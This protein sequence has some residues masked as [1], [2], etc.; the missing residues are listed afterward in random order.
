MTV[1]GGAAGGPVAGDPDAG[2]V[3]LLETVPAVRDALIREALTPP[4][5]AAGGG[6]PGKWAWADAAAHAA[7]HAMRPRRRGAGAG[8]GAPAR[9]AVSSADVWPDSDDDG[10]L[11]ALGG[12]YSADAFDDAAMGAPKCGKCGAPAEKRCSRC[13]NEWYCSREC[14]VAAWKGHKDVCDVVA[15]GMKAA[16]AAAAGG[17]GGVA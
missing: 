4:A 2:G 5:G 9:R 11:R 13:H 3:L 1:A 6:R 7:R 12:V 10:D 15:A 8:A 16:A 14:Q 17:G